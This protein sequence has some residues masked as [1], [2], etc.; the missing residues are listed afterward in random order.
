[1]LRF[2]I[3]RRT[4]DRGTGLQ[5]D[6]LETVDASCPELQRVLLGGGLDPHGAYDH[7]EVA[8]VEVLSL[9]NPPSSPNPEKP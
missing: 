5:V 2:I 1:M 4:L 6:A 9:S 8:G 7:R 3:R